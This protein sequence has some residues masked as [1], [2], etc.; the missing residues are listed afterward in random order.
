MK[1]GNCFRKLNISHKVNAHN[2]FVKRCLYD[3]FKLKNQLLKKM[4]VQ[5][6][7]YSFQPIRDLEP[8]LQRYASAVSHVA[9]TFSILMGNNDMTYM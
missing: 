1:K 6:S 5:I 9:I 7:L 3:T 8:M 2:M 4:F